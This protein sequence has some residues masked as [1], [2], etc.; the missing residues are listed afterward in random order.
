MGGF[1]GLQVPGATPQPVFDPDTFMASRQPKPPASLTSF[2]PDAFMAVRK[3][4]TTEPESGFWAGSPS[5]PG[6]AIKESS[7]MNPQK[8]KE[9]AITAGKTALAGAAAGSA[10]IGAAGVLAPTAAAETVGTGILDASGQEI[11]KEITRYGPSVA[12]QVFTHPLAQQALKYAVGAAGGGAILKWLG[13]LGK[14]A[15]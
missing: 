10:A 6:Q 2:D 1:T 7:T 15:E 14:A 12:R 11:M 5:I 9:G 4:Q 13:L 8:M 3:V